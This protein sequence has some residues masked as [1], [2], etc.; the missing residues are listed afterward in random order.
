M[1]A[2]VSKEVLGTQSLAEYCE[3]YRPFL[4]FLVTRRLLYCLPPIS[5]R[6]GGVAG[7]SQY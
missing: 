2:M 4:F 6:K 3:A 5:P 7:K 1:L